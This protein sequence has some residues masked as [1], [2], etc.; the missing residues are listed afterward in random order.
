MREAVALA[1]QEFEG[2]MVL[3]AHDRHLLRTA[4]DS[5]MLVADARLQSFDGDLEDYRAWLDARRAGDRPKSGAGSLRRDQKRTEARARQSLARARKPIE[6]KLRAVEA[7]LA[8]LEGEKRAIEARLAS[9]EFYARGDPDEVA[10][11]LREQSKIATALDKVEG[12]WL[13]LQAELE[14]VTSDA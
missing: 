7:D 10:G 14:R 8:R 4:T 11:A 13:E 6:T 9:A 1:L 2:A 3:V 12:Q 5:L